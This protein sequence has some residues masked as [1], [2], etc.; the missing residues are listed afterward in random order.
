MLRKANKLVGEVMN[1]LLLI[2]RQNVI[3]AH[4][5]KRPL[6]QQHLRRPNQ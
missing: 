6:K 4:Q 5:P 3:N 1:V 2:F